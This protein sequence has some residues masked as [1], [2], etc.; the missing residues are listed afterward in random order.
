MRCRL[1]ATL[2]SQY[3]DGF[4]IDSPT[5]LYAA[6]CT[7]WVTPCSARR[8]H[9]VAVGDVGDDE[10][11]AG[12][13]LRVAQ[14]QRVENDHVGAVGLQ[15]ADGVRADVAGAAGD[16]D[17][18]ERTTRFMAEKS[19]TG[20]AAGSALPARLVPG[21]R[22]ASP[23]S[24][25]PAAPSATRSTSACS[26]PWPRS[27]AG[28]ARDA[29][30][31][32][33]TSAGSMV[34][35]SLRAGLDPDDMRRRRCRPTAVAA[36]CSDGPPGRGAMR[37]LDRGGDGRGRRVDDAVSRRSPASPADCGWRRRSGFAGRSA[38]PGGSRPGSLVS[39]V[40][41]AGRRPTGHLRAPTGNARRS[42]ADR[43]LWI[44]AV[45]LDVGNRV[46]F[47]RDGAPA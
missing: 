28:I 18:H 4:S 8:G 24:S 10:G 47:G 7:A 25:G 36:R 31:I 23:S 13:R 11:H 38:N 45:D 26:A 22:L 21:P 12:D 14:L 41:P 29:E 46:V 2:L 33:G 34:G 40:V 5:L 35:A 44:V 17:G 3:R 39:A 30:L 20:V 32:V 15:A 6:K 16:Q 42:V 9:R 27:S 37:R 19:M 43:S 1:P